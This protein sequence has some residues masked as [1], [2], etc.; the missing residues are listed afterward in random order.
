MREYIVVNAFGEQPFTGNPVAVFMDC[1][2][3]DNEH[4]QKMAAEMNLSESTFVRRAKYGGDFNVAIFTPVNQLSF[5]GHPLLGTALAL[6]MKYGKNSLTLETGKGLFHFEVRPAPSV[7]GS[8]NAHIQM[9]LPTPEVSAYAQYND[10]LATLGI[11]DSTLP[12]EMYDV[13]PRHVFV[14]LPHIAALSALRPDHNRLAD[15][16]NMAALCFCPDG[17]GGWRIRM[18]SYAYGVVEDAAT[19]SAA[20]P[21]ALHL[22][23]H[24]LADWGQT[25]DILQGVEMGRPSRLQAVA[26]CTAQGPAIEASGYAFHTASGQYQF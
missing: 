23:R 20:G 4:M 18:F 6:A 14:G 9:Q 8:Y 11:E 17:T 13:G 19:G 16:P 2:D 25:V 22:I 1:D 15:H 10:L 24:G 26:H 7:N 12:V 21:F 3:L 5:A